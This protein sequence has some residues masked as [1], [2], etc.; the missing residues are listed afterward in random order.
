MCL[1]EDQVDIARFEGFSAAAMVGI[2][3]MIYGVLSS[4]FLLIN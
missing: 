4:F 1:F 2:P 3:Y